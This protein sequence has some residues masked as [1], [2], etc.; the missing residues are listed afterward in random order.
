MAT[1]TLL[2][3]SVIQYAECIETGIMDFRHLADFVYPNV[4]SADPF[5]SAEKAPTS[6]GSSEKKHNIGIFAKKKFQNSY[7]Q[8][9]P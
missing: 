4:L 6:D 7:N 1:K 2:L 3:Y 8:T 5:L 9:T